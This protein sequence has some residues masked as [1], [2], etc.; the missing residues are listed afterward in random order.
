MQTPARDAATLSLSIRPAVRADREWVIPLS[1]RLHEFGPPPW[2][3]RDRMN[4]AVASSL[5]IALDE[6]R[7]TNLILVAEDSLGE[8]LGFVHLQI[9]TDFFTAEDH[10]HISDLAVHSGAE[11]RGVASALLRAAEEWACA[12]GHRLLTMNVFSTN[13]RARALYDRSGYLPD[14]IRLVKV[15]RN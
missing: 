7:P 4:S 11:G 13:H 15:L 1:A 5:E 9:T 10:A 8:P 6:L 14:T 12:H 3:P 2:R